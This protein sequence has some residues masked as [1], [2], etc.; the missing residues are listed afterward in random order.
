ME[1]GGGGFE[2]HLPTP[3]RHRPRPWRKIGPFRALDSVQGMH[4]M[5]QPEIAAWWLDE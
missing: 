3:R 5:M 2:F 1:Y 4:Y